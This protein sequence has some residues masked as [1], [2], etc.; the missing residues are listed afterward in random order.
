MHPQN[1]VPAKVLQYGNDAVREAAELLIAAGQGCDF[2][3]PGEPTSREFYA[4]M[5]KRQRADPRY[6]HAKTIWFNFL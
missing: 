3:L 4:K 5:H 6:D 2:Y 1:Y